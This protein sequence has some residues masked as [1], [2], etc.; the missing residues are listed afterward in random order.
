[1][2]LA[3]QPPHSPRLAMLPHISVDSVQ[4]AASVSTRPQA[5]VT[6][7]GSA[8]GDAVNG[9]GGPRPRPPAGPSTAL[10][11]LLARVEGAPLDVRYGECILWMKASDVGWVGD[12]A[13]AGGGSASL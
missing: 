8:R 6:C 12:G 5:G 7:A 11:V 2:V 4:W 9:G 10:F 3:A 1:M 13:G